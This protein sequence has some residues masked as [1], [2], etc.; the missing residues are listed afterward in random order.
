MPLLLLKKLPSGWW[1]M[2]RKVTKPLIIRILTKRKNGSARKRVKIKYILLVL[3][4]DVLKLNSS[5]QFFFSLE[6][7]HLNCCVP[8]ICA[9]PFSMDPTPKQNVHMK[10]VNSFM[11]SLSTWIKSPPTFP[12][13]VIFTQQGDIVGVASPAA[14]P[15]PIWTISTITLNK[16]R[17]QRM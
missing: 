2:K 13:H 10:N 7:L 3:H 8:T 17:H 1:Q 12:V 9:R 11:T 14:L 15:V 16:K 4:D 5:N 6:K